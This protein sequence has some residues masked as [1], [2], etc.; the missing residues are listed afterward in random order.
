M[1]DVTRR[2]LERWSSRK[3]FVLA[4]IGSAVGLGSVW[5]FP[6][7]VGENGGG[8]FLLFYILGLLLVVFPLLIA[9]F[10]IGRHGRGS[11]AASLRAVAVESGR[12]PRW[13][14]VG[15]IGIATGFLILTY[16]AVIAGMTMAY[17]PLSLAAAFDGA[18][19]AA[20]RGIY[21]ALTGSAL[22][23]AAWQALFL[24][25]T[26]GVV[27]RGI[28]KGVEAAC[29]ILM[30]TLAVLMVLLVSYAII[31]GNVAQALAFLFRIDLDSTSGRAALE[32]LGLG[33]FSIG[34]GMGLMITY[35]GY[36]GED[37]DLSLAA[38]ATIAGDTAISILAGLAIFPIVFAEGLSP[39]EG[40]NLM[41]LTLPIAFGR[42]PLGD[43][44]GAAFFA[45]LFVAALASA[46]SLLEIVVAPLVQAL[47]WRRPAV[48]LM[49]G[50]GAWLAGIPTVLSFN[51][52]SDV[53][54][55]S[56]FAGFGEES[57]FDIVDGLASNLL[58]PLCGLLLSLFAGWRMRPDIYTTE[59]GR[60][61][62][63]PALRFLLRWAVP[64]VIVAYLV[65]GH[66]VRT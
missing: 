42:L 2:H 34:V 12:D 64:A 15:A 32:A 51:L 33:F 20:A 36:A 26:V 56:A 3:G 52:W 39:A 43:L 49:V 62:W 61:A 63:T 54:P 66:L 65:S 28:Q 31:E 48:A 55:L 5:K 19:A 23:L 10:V 47:G 46:I 7:E 8:T 29:K 27:A 59:L 14:L 4:T 35:A 21:A 16:Y 45:L 6:Y 40:A 13:R 25:T 18:D 24:V 38:V 58:L 22:E 50:V 44:V 37:F 1:M 17:V 41:F 53:R 9:E 11:A 57:V 30:P 60:A